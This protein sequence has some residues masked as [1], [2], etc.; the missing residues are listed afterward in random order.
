MF[1]DAAGTPVLLFNPYIPSQ[2][3]HSFSLVLC[4]DHQD[5]LDLVAISCGQFK[6]PQVELLGSL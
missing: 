1:S 2:P 3:S 4:F 5:E 6:F